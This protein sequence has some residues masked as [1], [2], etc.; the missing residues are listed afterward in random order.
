MEKDGILCF[1][2]T[3]TLGVLSESVIHSFIHSFME[4]NQPIENAAQPVT[5]ERGYKR[6]RIASAA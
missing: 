2:L 6:S 4:A 1:R 5:R 3:G